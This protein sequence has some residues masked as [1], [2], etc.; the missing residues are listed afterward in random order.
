M[1]RHFSRDHEWIEVAGDIATIGI[2][3]HAQ[4]QLGDVVFVDLPAVGK[5]VAKGDAAAVVESVKAASDVYA[6]VTGEVVEVNGAITDDPA[7]VNKEAEGGAWFMKVRLKN[8]AE[9]G[10]LMDA[11]AYKA[12]VEEGH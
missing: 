8:P 4:E 11:A 6:P 12:F 5:A 3:D 10:E 2:T 7:L 1:T 9:L